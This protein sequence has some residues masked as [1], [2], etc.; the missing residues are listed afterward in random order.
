MCTNLC[1]CDSSHVV[2]TNYGKPEG[3]FFILDLVSGDKRWVEYN[4]KF[5]IESKYKILCYYGDVYSNERIVSFAARYIDE[6]LFFN[7]EG[8]LIKANYFSETK[9]PLLTKDYAGIDNKSPTYTFNS[10]ATK[11]HFF[12]Q[13]IAVPIKDYLS[14]RNPT[15]EII[16]FDW[17]GNVVEVY[18]LNAVILCFCVDEDEGNIFTIEPQKNTQES[19]ILSKYF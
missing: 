3:L 18:K 13:R 15:S 7:I 1:Y 19:L 5:N 12:V 2:G 4:P 9:V 10:Y 16:M 14:F 8:K 6:V 17:E 11:D